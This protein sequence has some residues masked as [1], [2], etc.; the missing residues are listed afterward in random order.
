MA[1]GALT[2]F[3]LVHNINPSSLL[4]AVGLTS[5]LL[6]APN[7]LLAIVLPGLFALASSL[8]VKGEETMQV[9]TFQRRLPPWETPGPLDLSPTRDPSLCI[10]VGDAR[11]WGPLSR[12][13]CHWG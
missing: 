10:G 5:P 13:R 1:V 4:Q 11:H 7:S 3:R 8:C 2:A 6:S 9:P 12:F